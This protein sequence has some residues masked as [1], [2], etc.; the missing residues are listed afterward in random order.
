LT[1]SP[2]IPRGSFVPRFPIIY[3]GCQELISATWQ[4]MDANLGLCRFAY[5]EFAEPSFVAHALVLNESLFR[6]RN[7]KVGQAPFPSSLLS[8]DHLLTGCAKTHE[9]SWYVKPRPR[10]RCS[11]RWWPWLRRRTWRLST[12]RWLSWWLQRKPWS[13]L[14]AIL[15]PDG[16]SG[17]D[18][19][20]FELLA[21]GWRTGKRTIVRGHCDDFTKS[22]GNELLMRRLLDLALVLVNL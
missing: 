5:V 4:E 6:G 11:E 17:G 9:S 21:G 14:H 13:R 19:R 16:H 22:T 3:K 8:A 7:L 18:F 15:E 2:A 20:A 1:S 12:S 10:P